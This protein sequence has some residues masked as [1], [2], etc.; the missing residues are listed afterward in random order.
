MTTEAQREPFQAGDEFLQYKIHS[1]LGRG[2]HAFVYAGQHR[3]MERPVAIKVIPAPPEMNSDVYKRAR[4]EAKVLSQLE[5]PN[6]VKVYDAGVTDDG[7]IYIVM[8]MLQGRTLRDC[9][10]HLRRF[11]VAETFHVGIQIAEAVQ[12]AHC[13]NAIHRDLKPENV[14]VLCKNIVK[15]LDF[16]IAKL[17]GGNTMTTQPNLIRGTPQYMSPEHMEG[18][19]VTAQSDI[20]ALGSVLYELLAATPPAL[21]G[22][23]EITSY[24]IGYSQIHRMPPRL[25]EVARG[26]PR[27]VARA[28][29]RMLAK[30][31]TERQMSMNE[32]A[33]ELRNLQARFVSESQTIAEPLRELWR[34][35]MSA[36]S[37]QSAHGIHSQTTAAVQGVQS[38]AGLQPPTDPREI[39]AHAIIAQR[40][41]ARQSPL[42]PIPVKVQ[43]RPPR[44]SDFRLRHIALAVLAGGAIGYWAIAVLRHA[45]AAAPPIQSA[46]PSRFYEQLTPLSASVRSALLK[47]LESTPS[48]SQAPEAPIIPPAIATPTSAVKTIQASNSV[49]A[50]SMALSASDRS[51]A[52]SPSARM[53]WTDQDR[54]RKSSS[55][56]ASKDTPAPSVSAKPASSSTGQSKV[57]KNKDKLIF[58]ADDLNW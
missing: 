45:R 46:E 56:N 49:G 28:I 14:F 7:A 52:S 8:E 54:G 26:V 4:L 15:V 3:Y 21:I 57:S 42:G 22:L 48:K 58:G 12:V 23:Q 1:L 5:H 32:V 31:P 30:N 41:A 50:T 25:D 34:A 27:Y 11:T 43:S 36:P 47:P 20:Y 6:V 37:V 55:A 53:L 33:Q 13:Q 10:R 39:V 24:A 40:I 29:Q 44:E 51:A 18:R 2:G 38:P 17:L 16:G 35:E 19:P 9:L